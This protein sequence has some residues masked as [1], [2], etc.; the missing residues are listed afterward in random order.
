M[1]GY[2]RIFKPEMKIAEFDQ[3]QGVY[4]SL[5]K[6]LGKKY[7]A[8]SRMTLSYDFTFLSIFRMATAEECVGFQ[9]GR[10]SYNPLKKRL[11]CRDNPHVDFAADAATVLMYYKLRDNIADKRFFPSLPARFLMPFASSAHKKAAKL[12]PEL[13]A[14]IAA[15][16][17]RQAAL[18]QAKTPS[19]DEA[20]E[21]SAQM[22]AFLARMGA[23]DG[24]EEK[25]LDRF[26]YCLGRWIYL[27]DAVDDLDEDLE[28]GGYNPYIYSRGLTPGDTEAVRE[29]K[30]Y[31]LLTLNA[32]LA[33]CLAAYNLLAVRRFDGILRNILEWG[34]P[35][36]QKEAAVRAGKK[37]PKKKEP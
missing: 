17:E 18:E 25:I 1:F 28:E 7:G 26:G 9:K 15:C 27:V 13:D 3:Y 19:I 36:A 16:M 32:C 23:K 21:P 37:K 20:A 29:T 6:R 10:C 35:A 30:S 2:V 34:M 14:H 31:A 24:R 33:E 11:C 12:Y 22:L 5:C 4:C 8:M